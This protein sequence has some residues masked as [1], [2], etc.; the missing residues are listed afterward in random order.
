M[1]LEEAK[2][3]A[4]IRHTNVLEV[5]DLGEVEGLVYQV[6]PLVEGDS[7]ARLVRAHEQVQPGDRVPRAIA[8][9]ILVDTLRGLHAAHEMTA[10]DGVPLGI[11]HRDVSP[12]NI[13]VG[14]D[15]VSKLADFGVAKA[16]SSFG[17]ETATGALRGKVS[18]MSPEQLRK[19]KIDRRCDIFAT[20][21]ILWELLTGM[22]LAP[23]AATTLLS[24]ERLD[25]PRAHDP[26]IPP[27]FAELAMQALASSP[28]SRFASADAMGDALENAAAECGLLLSTKDV[29]SWTRALTVTSLARRRSHVAEAA[30]TMGMALQAS[31]LDVTPPAKDTR[32]RRAA[33]A[34]L[35]GVIATAGFAFL[36]LGLSSGAASEHASSAAR[37]NVAPEGSSQDTPRRPSMPSVISQG[38]PAASLESGPATDAAPAPVMAA[39]ARSTAPQTRPRSLRQPAPVHPQFANPYAP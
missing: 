34:A 24:G 37:A 17:D 35:A 31:V 28:D 8:I 36:A 39:P 2:L 25:D 5:F 19:A 27:K 32:V 3:A 7:L 29:G 26:T 38:A 33:I 16:I 18:Y 13:L 22:R 20:G 6:M 10:A 23:A 14:I 4:R 12:Q 1:F 9:R 11:V 30:G 21:V 15:G